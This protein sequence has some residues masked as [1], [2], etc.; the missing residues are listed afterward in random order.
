MKE[1]ESNIS[2]LKAEIMRNVKTMKNFN[3]KM[4]SPNE[5]HHILADGK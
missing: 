2:H 4:P 3:L 5:F 1:L